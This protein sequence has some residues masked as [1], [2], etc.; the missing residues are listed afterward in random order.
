MTDRA[1]KAPPASP[2]ISM[3]TVAYEDGSFGVNLY[4]TGLVSQA[5]ADAAYEFISRQL[6]GDEIKTQ[7]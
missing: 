1:T 6:C 3:Q 5:H 7:G 4:M 2:T